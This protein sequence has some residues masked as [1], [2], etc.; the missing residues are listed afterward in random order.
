MLKDLK[1]LEF[2]HLLKVF[3]LV[4]VIRGTYAGKSKGSKLCNAAIGISQYTIPDTVCRN[5][6]S[7]VHTDFYVKLQICF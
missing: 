1:L 5:I 7:E 4:T 3:T 2:L 6:A